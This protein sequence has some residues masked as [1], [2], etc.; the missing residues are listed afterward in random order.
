MCLLEEKTKKVSEWL[1]TYQGQERGS[2]FLK[3]GLRYYKKM[4][5][6]E[7]ETDY[8]TVNRKVL[9]KKNSL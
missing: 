8:K 7:N 9:K 6:F 1:K 3:F 5:V 4:D 2:V